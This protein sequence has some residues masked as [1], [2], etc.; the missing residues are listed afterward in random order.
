MTKVN[1]EYNNFDRVSYN[2]GDYFINEEYGIHILSCI[3]ANSS[4]LINISDG[5]KFTGPICVKDIG[6]ITEDEFNQITDGFSFK[7]IKEVTIQVKY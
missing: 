6:A 4:F 3:N 2:L 7:H 1:I 5:N